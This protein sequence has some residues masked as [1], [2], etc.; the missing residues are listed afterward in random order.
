[1]RILKERNRVDGLPEYYGAINSVV[2]D[3]EGVTKRLA[4]SDGR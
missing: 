4:S 2:S 1:M 3:K